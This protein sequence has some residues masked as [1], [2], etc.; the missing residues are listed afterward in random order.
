MNHIATRLSASSSRVAAA[1]PLSNFPSLDGRGFIRP[2]RIKGRVN[3]DFAT[4]SHPPPSRGRNYAVTLQQEYTGNY[5]AKYILLSL[6]AI[7]RMAK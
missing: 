3:K 2:W 4:P 5:R 1:Y 6:T 7:R